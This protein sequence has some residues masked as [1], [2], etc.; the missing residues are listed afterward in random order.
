VKVDIAEWHEYTIIA[1][2]NHLIHKLD[3]KVTVD[4]VDFDE[5]ARAMEGLL[6][7]QI[8]R[9]PAM[10]V[11]I[12]DVMLKDLPEG[13]V[14]SFEK[15]A[16][17]SDAQVIEKKEPKAKGKEKPKAKEPAPIKTAAPQPKVKEKG[18][19]KP[20]KQPQPKAATPPGS[21]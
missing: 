18:K 8:H 5:K 3:G 17:P 13:G 6:A 20:P 19:D 1:Q 11:Q 15:S 21:A 10:N 12:K 2:G 16:I 4:L 7:F 14:V 9:G